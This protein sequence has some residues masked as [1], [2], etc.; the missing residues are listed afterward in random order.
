MTTQGCVADVLHKGSSWQELGG[1]WGRSTLGSHAERWGTSGPGL[2][3]HTGS[4]RRGSMGQ[5]EP[6]TQSLAPT[7]PKRTVVHTP[8]GS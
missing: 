2:G 4:S 8:G 5:N 3:A 1:G 7:L 6:V